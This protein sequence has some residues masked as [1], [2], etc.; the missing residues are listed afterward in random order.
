M[1]KQ[2]FLMLSIQYIYLHV[3]LLNHLEDMYRMPLAAE[4]LKVYDA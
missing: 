1:L 2:C 4:D 3:P